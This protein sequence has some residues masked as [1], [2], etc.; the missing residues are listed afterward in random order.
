MAR[1][2]HQEGA[3]IIT[4]RLVRKQA[5]ALDRALLENALIVL[6]LHI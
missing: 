1:Q 3:A 6:L 2:V 4:V 5:S